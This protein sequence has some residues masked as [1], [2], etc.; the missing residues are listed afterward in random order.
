[1]SLTVKDIIDY[2]RSN[3]L[4]DTDS[5][6]YLWENA[7]LI[8]LLNRAYNEIF[9]L[10]GRKDQTTTAIVQIALLSN[11]GYY[12][13]DSRILKIDSARL[14]TNTDYG[15][16]QRELESRLDAIV[17]D[18]RSL[19]GTPTKYCPGAYSNYLTV[20]PKFDAT[21]EY[22]GSSDISFDSATKTI[23]Q[24]D[25]DFSDLTAGDQVVVTGSGVTANNTTFTVATVGTDSF[26]VSETVTDASN[27]SATIRKVRDTLLLSATVLPS[28]RFS[29]DD[30]DNA[31]E[32]TELR[33]DH[34]EGLTDGIAKRAFLKPD[35]YAY[36]PQKA[37]YHRGLFEEF[38][39]Q[40]KRDIILLHKPDHTR[41]IRSGTGIGY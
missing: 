18:W 23:S 28:S 32:I 26:T 37:E 31:T 12:A 15:A 41:V 35:T 33:D 30:Y 27:T 7:E 2:T 29:T 25:G 13:I 4:D 17:S 24:T 21:A 11:L 10:Y 9:K 19:T 22:V 14:S 8:F 16:L 38:K 1:M 6:K 39:R 40:V 5:Q 36:F 20:Y 3:V 34:I